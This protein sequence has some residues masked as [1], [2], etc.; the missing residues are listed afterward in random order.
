THHDRRLHV[1]VP[2]HEFEEDAQL[3]R[4]PRRVHAVS[5]VVAG[6]EQE[7]ARVLVVSLRLGGQTVLAREVDGPQPQHRLRVDH[8]L[9]WGC[10]V[11]VSTETSTIPL[12]K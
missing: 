7:D 6:G 10:A 4:V 1:A 8:R 3:L 12:R 2:W 5:R 9:S 11:K